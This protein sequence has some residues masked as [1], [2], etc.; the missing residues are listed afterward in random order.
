MD[1]IPALKLMKAS[2]MAKLGR[3]VGHDT[4]AYD[5]EEA[6]GIASAWESWGGAMMGATEHAA[7]VGAFLNGFCKCC[8]RGCGRG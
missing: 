8:G 4:S 1:Q 3:V 5:D 7:L 6:G 2:E